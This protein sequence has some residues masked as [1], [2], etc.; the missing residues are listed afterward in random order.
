MPTT[1]RASVDDRGRHAIHDPSAARAP[2]APGL[3]GALPERQFR[4]TGTPRSK[5]V[6]TLLVWIC[7][8]VMNT[9]LP[10]WRRSSNSCSRRLA[11]DGRPSTTTGS[12]QRQGS[13]SKM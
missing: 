9:P 1:G 13:I 2:R 3:G 7:S 12:S 4:R 5:S 10:L 8:S 6:A 11:N